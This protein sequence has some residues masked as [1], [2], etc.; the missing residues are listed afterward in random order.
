MDRF[1]NAPEGV[2]STIP[3]EE[4]LAERLVTYTIEVEGQLV[5]VE[6]VPARV[7]EETGERFYAPETVERLQRII[8][9]QQT[10]SRIIEA[11]VFDFA[12]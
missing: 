10:P 4:M 5:V 12:A 11:P 7:N 3:S 2:M 6:N 9:H 1:P 8:E